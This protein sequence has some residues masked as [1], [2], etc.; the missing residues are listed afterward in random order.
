MSLNLKYITVC[1]IVLVFSN[2]YQM[3]AYQP[4]PPKLGFGPTGSFGYTDNYI[5]H[6]L[7]SRPLSSVTLSPKLGVFLEKYLSEYADYSSS[8]IVGLDFDYSL[9]DFNNTLLY[10]PVVDT[11]NNEEFSFPTNIV[12]ASRNTSLN[13][14]FAYRVPLDFIHHRVS[15]LLGASYQLVNNSDVRIDFSSHLD[16]TDLQFQKS[17]LYTVNPDGKSINETLIRKKH[18]ELSTIFQ[19]SYHV[20][21]NDEFDMIRIFLE[22][23]L[24]PL[25]L[26]DEIRS[27]Y[28]LHFGVMYYIGRSQPE[29]IFR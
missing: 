3:H 24:Y 14:M 13:V 8:I 12:Y 15:I 7:F 16:S 27:Q 19:I 20:F 11:K 26:K 4:K 21:S 10:L 22:S 1:L 18:N 28:S 29:E 23:N 17:N 5:S 2:L 25:S 6:S 9:V